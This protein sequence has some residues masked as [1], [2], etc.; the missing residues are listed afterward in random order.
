MEPSPHLGL[1][2]IQ[3]SKLTT[4]ALQPNDAIVLYT[5][6]LYSTSKPNGANLREKFFMK[7]LAL[8]AETAR[9]AKML[10]EG[11]LGIFDDFREDSPLVDDISVVTVRRRGPDR[12][13]H[14]ENELGQLN[15]VKVASSI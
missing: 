2:L 10:T 6:G 14:L 9:S 15:H 1:G 7:Q 3:G 4:F 12:P 5:D 13:I 11:I 8:R